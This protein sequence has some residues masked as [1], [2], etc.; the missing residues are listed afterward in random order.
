[1]AY[2]NHLQL[3]AILAVVSLTH[4]GWASPVADEPFPQEYRE[5]FS[6]ESEPQNDVRALALD[7][8]GQLW[9]T[10][11]AG[12]FRLVDGKFV[13]QLED[14]EQGPAFAAAADP[15]GDVWLGTWNG[16]YRGT[17]EGRLEKMAKIDTPI[18]AIGAFG[19]EIVAMGPDGL[20]RG[21]NG[22]W[23][24][25]RGAW[26][27]TPRAVVRDAEN[28][29]WI[30]TGHGLFRLENFKVSGHYWKENELRS[31]DVTDAALAPDGR[32]YLASASG[33]DIYRNGRPDASLTPAEGLPHAHVRCLA[34]APDGVLWA[35]T[36]IG[37]ARYDGKVWSLR[38]SLRWLPDDDVRDIAFGS[39]GTAW[40]ATGKG[41]AAIK[42]RAMT[43]ADKATY[44]R[45]VV[46]ARK[47]REPGIVAI[48]RL[49][50]PGDV[51]T[52]ISEDEDNDGE[53]TQHYV[54]TEAFRYAVT[55]D[56][57]A[58][59]NAKRSFRAMKFLQEVTGTD[60]F[61]ARTVAP[62]EW[63]LPDNPNPFR[64]HD[65]NKTYTA[66][67]I[68]EN[69]VYDP[70][71]KPVEERW[72]PSSDGKWLWKGDTSSDEITGHYFGYLH[73]YDLVAETEAEKEEVRTL[74][75]RVTDYLIEG[76]LTLRDIDG[77]HTRWGVWSPEK[78][79]GDMNWFAERNINCTEMLGYLLTAWH[80]T[81]D[82]KYRRLYLKLAQEHGYADAARH[83]KIDT[84]AYRTHIDDSLLVLVFPAL[85]Q[86]EMDPRLLA[87]YREGLQQWADNVNHE[88][89]PLFNFV[90]DRFGSVTDVDAAVAFLR[91]APL[92][93]I[94]WT[95]DNSQR[96]DV[97]LVRNPELDHWQLDRLLPPSER[98]VIRWDK[99]PWS[100]IQ[101][102]GGQ[103]ESTGVYWLLPYWMGRY[104]GLIAAPADTE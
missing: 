27:D 22:R 34:F 38:H 57:Q 86:C 56:P 33:I 26:A 93:L 52:S 68:A 73:Y 9:I 6:G 16:L 97:R 48:T 8:A 3:W 11:A 54:V 96:E 4:P 18:G 42:K 59:Q 43:L 95:V 25:I 47:V 19:D 31:S 75:R 62:V 82:D 24:H 100:A 20:W 60:G 63:T 7:G 12:V 30:P 14:S 103:T 64:F 77:R 49:L 13:R 79:F 50:T 66:R 90:A 61:I 55:R 53:Y 91:D 83:P 104:Y 84:P 1:M 102:D 65:R 37:A 44:F 51:S 80:I 21:R 74:V 5:F 98:A 32:L 2:V 94:H 69:S 23:K 45:E 35:G 92:D 81:G 28:R 40:I 87:C 70:R 36:A 15:S 17:P 41:V 88:N 46:A 10:S 85:F 39:D 67:D 76:G 99:N 71:Y 101:G 58:K 29:L 89:S 78:L 72:R